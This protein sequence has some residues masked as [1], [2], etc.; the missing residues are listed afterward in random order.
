MGPDDL[1]SFEKAG[2]RKDTSSLS[3][4]RGPDRGKLGPSE[5]RCGSGTRGRVLP[6]S[7]TV[8]GGGRTRTRTEVVPP[9]PLYLSRGRSTGSL[10]FVNPVPVCRCPSVSVRGSSITHGSH[11]AREDIHQRTLEGSSGPSWA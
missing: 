2:F 9:T 5:V 4:L 6:V 1:P 3:P 10:P 11:T 7:E 8:G